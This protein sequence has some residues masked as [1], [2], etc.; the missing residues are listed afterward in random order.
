VSL[1]IDRTIPH[2]AS[3]SQTNHKT[4]DETNTTTQHEQPEIKYIK[5]KDDKAL[6]DDYKHTVQEKFL[7]SLTLVSGT[8]TTAE[9]IDNWTEEFQQIITASI[10][11]TVRWQD[12]TQQAATK[13]KTAEPESS[14]AT[15]QTT[16]EPAKSQPYSLLPEHIHTYIHTY[17]I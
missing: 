13:A 8:V 11:E 9:E 14:N 16:E 5:N 3:I 10:A 12:T 4:T 2:V 1:Q 17:F 7:Q 15:D 6:W